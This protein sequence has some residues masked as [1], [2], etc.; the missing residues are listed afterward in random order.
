MRASQ[1][2]AETDDEQASELWEGRQ[3]N[4]LIED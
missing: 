1:D 4:M 2:Q 3:S